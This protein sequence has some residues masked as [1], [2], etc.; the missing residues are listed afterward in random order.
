LKSLA[1]IYSK[2]KY[3]RLSSSPKNLEKWGVVLMVGVRRLQENDFKLMY[4]TISDSNPK[5]LIELTSA[6]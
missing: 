1:S 5:Q 2:H 3:N 4:K 6:P